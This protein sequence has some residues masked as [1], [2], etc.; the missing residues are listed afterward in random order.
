MNYY[1]EIKETLI[2]N[3]IYK[4]VKDYSKNKS[5]LNTYFEV[6]RLIVEAQGG[7]ARAK[8]GNKLIKEYSEK[9]TKELGKGYTYTNLSRMRQFYLLMQ[10]LAPMAQQLPNLTWSH[11]SIILPLK[12]LKEIEYYLY[13]SYKEKLRTEKNSWGHEDFINYDICIC[14]N[15]IVPIVLAI[16]KYSNLDINNVKQKIQDKVNWYRENCKE[17]YIRQFGDKDIDIFDFFENKRKK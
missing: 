16:K 13:I 9:L 6:G 3:E 1:N 7:E 2:K 15:D 17:D 10:K 8:Y 12:N 4:K 5:D 11:Y 14:G